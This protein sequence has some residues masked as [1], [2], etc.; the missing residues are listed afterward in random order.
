MVCALCVRVCV[1]VSH[2]SQ[3]VYWE[4]Q[5]RNYKKLGTKMETVGQL[6][7]SLCLW[8]SLSFSD[9]LQCS[10]PQQPGAQWPEVT[11]HIQVTSFLLPGAPNAIGTLFPLHLEP[12]WVQQRLLW[13]SE[14]PRPE[15]FKKH[16]LFPAKK[17][18]CFLNNPGGLSEVCRGHPW[19]LWALERLL[20]VSGGHLWLRP[21]AQ[22]RL[23]FTCLL[24]PHVP[25]L[26]V[27]ASKQARLAHN[28]SSDERKRK[29]DS[30]TSSWLLRMSLVGLALA[31][32]HRSSLHGYHFH[33]PPWVQLTGICTDRNNHEGSI[34]Q[35]PITYLRILYAHTD[36]CKSGY[37]SNVTRPILPQRLYIMASTKPHL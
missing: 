2:S 16:F 15:V 26:Q 18:S 14:S 28:T 22:E 12:F 27:Q 21:R 34:F 8:F 6:G 24:W 9:M 32:I 19:S 3:R 1:Y 33:R 20:D 36:L 23:C 31:S 30:L 11:K 29:T 4:E 37:I 7:C 10:V 35:A 17:Q 5:V 25:A 13:A